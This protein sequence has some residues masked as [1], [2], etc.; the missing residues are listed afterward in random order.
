MNSI[1]SSNSSPRPRIE[2]LLN[3]IG[4]LKNQVDRLEQ[5]Y[6]DIY[7]VDQRASQ[8]LQSMK[9]PLRNAERDNAQTDVSFEGRQ[10]QMDLNSA[11]RNLRD[12][13][14]RF[15]RQRSASQTA[16]GGFGSSQNDL[17][18]II[19]DSSSYPAALAK[20][21]QSEQALAA[22]SQDHKDAKSQSGWAENDQQRTTSELRWAENNVRQVSYDRPGLDVS[23]DARQASQHVDQADWSLRDSSNKVNSAQSEEAKSERGLVQ[24]ENLLREA[25]QNLPA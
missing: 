25:L 10:A 5:G 6:S 14:S 18:A 13:D 8:D 3:D 12:V 11:E 16:D 19:A 22:S 24:V 2:K 15:A 1:T 7:S 20:L 17:K 21:Q 4:Q 9:W 23:Y